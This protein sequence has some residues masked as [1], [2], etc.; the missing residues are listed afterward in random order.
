MT[1]RSVFISKTVYPWFEEVYVNFDWFGGFALSQK[2][3]CELGLHLNFNERYPEH[4]VL[5]I[6]SASTHSL[7]NDLSA[8]HLKKETVCG[9][10]SVESAF[11]SSRIYGRGNDIVGPFPE[12]LM[13]DGRECKKRVKELSGGRHSYRYLF[14][15]KEFHAP[16]HHI[17]QFY[18]WLYMNA[19]LEEEN[20]EVREKLIH[21]G[22]TAFSDLATK[23]LNSQAR[24]CAIFIGLYRAGLLDQINDFDSYLALFR[25]THNGHAIDGSAY[26]NVQLLQEKGT[27]KLLSRPVACVYHKEDVEKYY[28]D[29]CSSLH[30]RKTSDNYLD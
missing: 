20:R 13:V 21:G 4:K 2:R 24:S 22:Y 18:D 26:E 19:L 10:T 7:G 11:Q 27:V 29:N 3:K 14:E 16:V 9:I 23:A 30:N 8:M 15:G 12:L 17:S 5:E 25:T 1:V 6:S 28:A